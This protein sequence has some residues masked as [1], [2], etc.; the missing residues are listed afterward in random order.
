MNQLENIFQKSDAREANQKV[1][2]RRS[3]PE[4]MAQ[5]GNRKGPFIDRTGMRYGMLT[6]IREVAP[7]FT[8]GGI[9]RRRWLCLCDC[10]KET[11][12]D[13]GSLSSNTHSCG[14]TWGERHGMNDHPLYAR[15]A[16]MIAR[17]ENP[18]HKDFHSYGGRNI[19]VC[20]RWR[21]SFKTF[22]D[23]M[24]NPPTPKH[25]I[26]RK[27]SNGNYAPENCIWATLTQQARN[28]RQNHL[29]TIDGV[30]LCMS[31]WAERMGVKRS[32]I[33]CRIKAGWNPQMAVLLPRTK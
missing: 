14:C 26:E 17:C 28:T 8:S 18:K 11:T 7:R 6:A 16:G 27:D 19:R 3:P 4:K 33:K 25:T 23:D 10:G 29:I 31:E 21:H 20:E 24:G 13:S 2:Q 15:W 9:K 5:K 1:E 30:T 22:V 12:V 32:M